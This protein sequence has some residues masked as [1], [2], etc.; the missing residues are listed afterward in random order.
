MVRGL[1]LRGAAGPAAAVPGLRLQAD[2]ADAHEGAGHAPKDE[3]DYIRSDEALRFL[4]EL[5]AFPGKPWA[6]LF[7]EASP[8]A[9]DLLDKLLQFHPRKRITVDEALAHPYF[10]SVRSQYTDPDPVLP[11]GPGGFEF[12]FEGDDTLDVPAF[13]RLL[14]EEAI[15]FRAE[16]AL[17][18]RAGTVAAPASG[19]GAL[20]G[21]H[22]DDEIDMGAV[23]GAGA[24][25]AGPATVVK[26]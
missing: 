10:D 4:R 25:P 12:S 5:P 24:V 11:V 26:P 14:V 7:P 9:L 17:A 21:S 3:T 2:A 16:K 22:H 15:S 20:S 19:V 6:S 23:G 8:K 1:H 13:K 18:A